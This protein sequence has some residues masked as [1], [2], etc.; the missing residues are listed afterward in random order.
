MI[1]TLDES[2][3]I[4]SSTKTGVQKTWIDNQVKNAAAKKFLR[5][6]C[7]QNPDNMLSQNDYKAQ[8]KLV[9]NLIK[10][11]LRHFYQNK[12]EKQAANS[13]KQIVENIET[14]NT[15]F[16]NIGV[17]LA[18]AFD[19]KQKYEIETNTNTMFCFPITSSEIV[20]TLR[21]LL[22][23][24]SLDCHNINYFFLKKISQAA[25]PLLETLFNAC[26]TLVVFP[27]CLKIAKIV[28]S[29][30]SG[31]RSKPTNYRQTHNLTSSSHWQTN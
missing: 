14:F 29:F 8:C 21:V 17:E 30:K 25:S 9:R 12:I 16:A 27:Q 15:F 28:P 23:K 19:T 22:S 6:L 13:N 10:Q 5:K 20:D 11:K 1:N 2:L 31:D 3:P 24:F 18:K 26:L 4:I 7:L